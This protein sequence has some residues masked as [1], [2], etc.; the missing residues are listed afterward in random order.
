M[1]TKSILE[2]AK[3]KKSRE[4]I[5]NDHRTKEELEDLSRLQG[6]ESLVHFEGHSDN[7][8]ARLDGIDAIL[9][10]SDHE[11]LPMIL[12]EAMSLQIPIIAHAVGGIPHLLDYGSCGVLV[13]DNNASAYAREIHRLAHDPQMYSKLRQKALSRVRMHY[14]AKNCA[15][16]YLHIYQSVAA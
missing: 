13:Q 16:N 1:G 2:D 9:M 15:N 12:L 7:L 3:R 14:S 5:E 6:T 8:P 10:T 11:G 4:R